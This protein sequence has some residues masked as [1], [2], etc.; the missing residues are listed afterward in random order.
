MIPPPFHQVLVDLK[1]TKDRRSIVFSEEHAPLYDHC[2]CHLDEVIAILIA[3]VIQMWLRP[4]GGAE[5]R[6]LKGEGNGDTATGE[7]VVR[8]S[9][10]QHHQRT[11]YSERHE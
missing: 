7:G 3:V 8:Q 9:T 5:G 1:K 10:G 11:S 4:W 6:S 2:R